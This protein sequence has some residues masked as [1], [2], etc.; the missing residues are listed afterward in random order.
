[1]GYAIRHDSE[2]R[3]VPSAGHLPVR[4]HRVTHDS[5]GGTPPRPGWLLG[6]DR[7]RAV[8]RP[9]HLQDAVAL[10]P[11][12]GPAQ[13]DAQLRPL[14]RDAPRRMALLLPAHRYGSRHAP[15]PLHALDAG[16]PVVDPH[17]CVRRVPQVPHARDLARDDRPGDQA[18][19]ARGRLDRAQHVLLDSR[20]DVRSSSVSPPARETATG[21]NLRVAITAEKSNEL[22]LPFDRAPARWARDQPEWLF[23]ERAGWVP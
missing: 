5:E 3:R 1:M 15:A 7:R 19:Q 8:G 11:R 20:P 10:D 22:P 2:R 21:R 14:L 16:H 23:S 18:R 9:A 6:L 17:L 4:Q 13:L 12:A